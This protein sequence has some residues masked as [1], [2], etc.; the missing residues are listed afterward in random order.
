MKAKHWCWNYYSKDP[1]NSLKATCKR[2]SVTYSNGNI[3]RMLKHLK[4][5]KKM[6]EAERRTIFERENPA[7]KLKPSL[8]Q[9]L[10]ECAGKAADKFAVRPPCS[11]TLD[12]FADKMDKETQKTADKLFVRV[13]FISFM[14]CFCN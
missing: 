14:F 13:S 10:S 11:F 4:K 2:C 7:K 3:D 12:S 8:T 6:T 9:E 1:K 5:C